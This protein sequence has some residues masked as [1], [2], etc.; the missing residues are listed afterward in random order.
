MLH[1]AGV[2]HTHKSLRKQEQRAKLACSCPS[3]RE[4]LFVCSRL[5]CRFRS[6]TPLCPKKPWGCSRNSCHGK[7]KPEI[8]HLWFANM[9]LCCCD[10]VGHTPLICITDRP[11]HLYDIIRHLSWQ[12]IVMHQIDFL[13]SETTRWGGRLP[14][15]WGRVENLKLVFLSKVH[16]LPTK[17]GENN[18]VPGMSRES[19]RD[20]P[21]P[22][23]CSNVSE[24]S[25][26]S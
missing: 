16:S 7:L 2:P 10:L 14:R 6:S 20:V 21:D 19:C 26:C 18:F 1:A 3:F 15:E 25:S 11:S 8:R 24:K 4:Q 12:T 23:G 9:V 22:W 17:P 5:S 13:G